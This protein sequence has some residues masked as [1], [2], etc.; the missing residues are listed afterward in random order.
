[1][2]FQQKPNTGSLFRN[3]RKQGAGPD[4]KGSLNVGGVDYWI[5]GWMKES[6]EGKKYMSLA[7]TPKDGTVKG[8]KSKQEDADTIPF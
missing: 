6:K 1:M 5:A 8:D 7:V 2:A 4:Y 3:D